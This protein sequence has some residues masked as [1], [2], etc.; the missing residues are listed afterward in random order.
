MSQQLELELAPPA[1]VVEIR[2]SPRRRSLSIEV[3]PDL[4]V[5]LRV[6][7]RCPEVLAQQFLA[8]RGD[9][10]DRQ[11]AHFRQQP[12]RRALEVPREG[13]RLA[14]LG[15]TIRVRRLPEARSGLEFANGELLLRGRHAANDKAAAAALLRWFQGEARVLFER[16]IDHWHV[17]PRLARYAR[18]P[19]KIRAMR[20]RWGSLSPRTG[21]TLNLLLVHAPLAAIEY[22]VVHELCHLRYHG[23]GKGF[24]GLLEAV[25]PDWKARKKLLNSGLEAAHAVD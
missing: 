10:I 4:R 11:L 13:M 1:P 5:I 25:L 16:L 6:P 3:H 15:Q 14:L 22:V 20:S 24:Y 19:L 8:S 2:R 12:P 18:P 7:A 17:H 9:W 21:M 23:H